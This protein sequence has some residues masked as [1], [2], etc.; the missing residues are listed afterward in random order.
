[1]V[2]SVADRYRFGRCGRAAGPSVR[3]L[4]TVPTALFAP[5]WTGNLDGARPSNAV[6]ALAVA[7]KRTDGPAADKANLGEHLR[8]GREQHD[9]GHDAG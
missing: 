4:K 3:L 1:L 9:G 8:I 7:A 2:R 6:A 5:T